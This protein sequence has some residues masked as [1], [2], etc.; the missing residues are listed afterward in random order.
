[1]TIEESYKPGMTLLSHRTKVGAY[2][3]KAGSPLLG[4]ERPRNLLL[5]FCHPQVSLG[6]IIGKWD[7]KVI[8]ESQHLISSM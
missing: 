8:Q 1:M 6:L 2:A 7:G 3:T 4:S 5:D